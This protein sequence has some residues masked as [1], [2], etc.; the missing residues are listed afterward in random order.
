[1]FKKGI[2]L[3][4]I[5]VL[6]IGAMI[7]VGLTNN[8]GT[9]YNILIMPL[10]GAIGYFALKKRWYYVPMGILALTFVWVLIRN[11]MEGMLSQGLIGE[12]LTGSLFFS[13]IYI[14]L[15]MIGVSIA[16][17]LKYAFGREGKV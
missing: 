12:A 16:A 3:F 2:Y 14:I 8:K 6:L 7:G 9:F 10:L 5:I 11:A 15:A 17:L 13:M 1:M 4:S